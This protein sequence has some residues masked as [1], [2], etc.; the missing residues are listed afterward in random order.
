MSASTRRG[1]L[2]PHDAF[3]L[4]RL[5]ARSQTDPRKATA[6]L[7][8][9]S[10]DAG[11]RRLVVTRMRERGAAILKV[12]DDGEG[13]LPDLTRE[14]ALEHLARNIG[15]S[16]KHGLSLEERRGALGRYG[17]GILGF[18]AI[19]EELE[20]RTRVHGGPVLALRLREDQAG[21]RILGSSLSTPTDDDDPLREPTCTEIVVRRIHDAA[22]GALAGR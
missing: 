8:Q 12:A 1:T 14:D 2:R 9:N 15:H 4:I 11:A 16:R 17:I 13:V 20:L 21:Y 5:L 10:L 18:W 6:E 7:V 19:G 22:L 3:D